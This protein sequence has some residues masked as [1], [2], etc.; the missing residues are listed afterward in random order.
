M[1]FCVN[2]GTEVSDT[3]KLCSNCGHEAGSTPPASPP[4]T[5]API[6]PPPSAPPAG[7]SPTFDWRRVAVGNWSGAG[8]TALSALLVTGLLSGVMA[9]LLKPADFG[10][11]NTLTL[12]AVIAAGAFGADLVIDVDAEDVNSTLSLGLFPLTVTIIALVVAVLM[13]RRIIQSYQSPYAALGDAARAALI[14]GGALMLPALIFRSDNDETGRGWGRGISEEVFGKAE[15]HSNAASAFFLGFLILFTVLSLTV[16]LAGRW[17]HEGLRRVL[18]WV[19]APLYGHATTFALLPVAGLIGWLLLGFGEDSIAANDP[20]ADDLKALL[21]LVFGLL[22]SG[23]VWVM[24]LG[25]GGAIGTKEEETDERDVTDWNHLWGQVTD[26][27]PGLW[28]APAVMLAVLVISAVVVVRR[29]P[30]DKVLRS[31]L[32]WVGSLL[33]V[34]PLMVRLSGGHFVGEASFLGEDYE[35]SAYFGAHGVQATFYLTGVALLVAIAVAAITKNLD[36]AQLRRDVAA[37]LRTLQ[38]SPP[39]PPSGAPGPTHPPPSAPPPPPTA[40]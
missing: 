20:T 37:S 34:V 30:H 28:A 24:T 19:V 4:P 16:L 8:L 9:L 12:A 5:R 13:F 6:P 22:A 31:L 1:P 2:C 21:T 15:L 7:S 36:L 38:S 11:D 23:G 25:A 14:F 39:Q 27:E 18:D 3:T 10:I 35:F 33:A 29:A 32:V 40:Q 17:P 26:D